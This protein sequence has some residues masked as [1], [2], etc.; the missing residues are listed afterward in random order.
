MIN[1]Q[2]NANYRLTADERQFIVL[3]RKVIDPTKAPGY[4]APE[5]APPPEKRERYDEVAYISLTADGLIRVLEYVRMRTVAEGD[6]KT[7]AEL[8]A[9]LTA[10]TERLRDAVSAVTSLGFSVVLDA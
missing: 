6:A 5:G 9:E 4:K 10:E 7:L 1:V 8:M 3:Q 2:L